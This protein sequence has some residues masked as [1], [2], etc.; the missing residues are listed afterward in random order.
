MALQ[1]AGQWF[2]AEDGENP[3]FKN[4]EVI[5]QMCEV[6]KKMYEADLIYPVDYFSSEGVGAFRMVRS[7]HIYQQYGIFQH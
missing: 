2:Y 6:L 1:S 3:N 5:R 4:N 7:L